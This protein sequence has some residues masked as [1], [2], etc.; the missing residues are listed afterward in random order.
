MPPAPDE[1]LTTDLLDTFIVLC[2]PFR[3]EL[4]STWYF[5]TYS[6]ARL[7]NGEFTRLSLVTPYIPDARLTKE[8]DAFPSAVFDVKYF[9]SAFSAIAGVESPNLGSATAVPLILAAV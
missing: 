9:P 7:T 8:P 6:S 1:T 4:K 3:N 5:G 2:F